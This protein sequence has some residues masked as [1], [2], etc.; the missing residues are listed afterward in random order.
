MSYMN[1]EESWDLNPLIVIWEVTRACALAC[2]HC[3]AEAAPRRDP[4]ELNLEEAERFI[5]Q[6]ARAKPGIFILT[7]GDPA[8]RRDL[9]HIIE[10]ASK[11][12]LY[13]A[14]SPSATP[15][16]LKADLKMLQQAG[17]RAI[18]LSLDGPD[19]DSHD[20]FRGVRGTW[21]W[22]MQAC[23]AVREAGINLQ[24]NT[25]ISRWNI[26]RFEDFLPRIAELKPQT[27]S[28]FQLVPTGRAGAADMVTGEQMETLFNRLCEVEPSLGCKIK[29]TEGMH[30]R[31]VALQRWKRDGGHRPIVGSTNDGKGFVF[32]SHTGDICP[33]GFLPLSAGN[34]RDEELLDVYRGSTLFHKLRDPSLLKGKCG[35]CEY[36]EICGG[37]RARAYATTG[38]YLAEEPL[39]IYQP[40]FKP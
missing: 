37:S 5:D 14:M 40:E 4:N 26:D 13:V 3:R 33:S 9:V 2:R 18:S 21:E 27:W 19:K 36:K 30:Y 25:T 35:R 12:D 34:V 10:S 39:C 8:Y 29:T 38:D 31:R 15:R 11:K 23:R 16:F 24:I 1:I 6:V 28:V 17:L 20:A 7:G 22:T 32:V